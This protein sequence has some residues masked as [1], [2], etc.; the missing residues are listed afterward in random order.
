MPFSRKTLI[1]LADALAEAF[2]H[3]GLSTLFYEFHVEARD[4]G[5]GSNKQARSLAM[6]R[7]IEADPD[8][9]RADETVL[10][11][12]NRALANDYTRQNYA[13]LLASLTVDG[14]EWGRDRLVPAMPGP[15]PLTG[16]VTAL[17]IEL[18]QRGF[19]VAAT[20]YRQAVDNF[21][22][23]NFEACNGQLRSY[24]EDLLSGAG[25]QTGAQQ[26]VGPEG[27]LEHLRRLG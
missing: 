23:G 10:D 19:N 9:N 6:I 18:Q 21:T 11:L 7:A 3:A 27:A 24:L 25:R 13:A 22:D 15:A 16:E 4:P 14:F 2:S 17:E 26:N 1:R 20:H 12:A 5:I 8:Q